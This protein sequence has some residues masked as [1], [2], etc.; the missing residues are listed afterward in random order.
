MGGSAEGVP[1]AVTGM[2]LPGPRGMTSPLYQR[3][4]ADL[5]GQ[6]LSGRLKPGERLPATRILRKQYDVADMT[7]RAALHLLRAEG[8][9]D[10]VQG[11]GTYVTSSLPRRAARE[12]AV[13]ETDSGRLRQLEDALRDVLSHIG[14]QGHPSWE[15]NTCLVSDDQLTRWWAVLG[16]TPQWQT[17]DQQAR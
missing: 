10:I 15:L 14:P 12:A 4:A 17:P 16:A 11:R 5:R 9:V 2:P 3:M 7:A 8:L 1:G 13:E 6:I